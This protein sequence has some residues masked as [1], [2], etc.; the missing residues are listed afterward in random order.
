MLRDDAVAQVQVN[1]GF[2]RDL[3]NVIILQL[4]QAQAFY[5]RGPLIPWFLE[6]EY[7]T[8]TSTGPTTDNPPIYEDRIPLPATFLREKE[9]SMLEWLATDP[10]TTPPTWIPLDKRDDDYL[11]SWTRQNAETPTWLQNCNQVQPCVFPPSL[12]GP[13]LLYSINAKYYRIAPYPDKV[14][15]LRQKIY[16]QDVVLTANTENQWLKYA[17]QLLI[18]Y[19]TRVIAGSTGNQN[20]LNLGTSQEQ[21]ALVALQNDHEWREATNSSYAMGADL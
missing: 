15:T 19:A 10:S 14:Y 21:N 11:N 18:G 3:T 6:T 5:E 12:K 20:A 2:R 1:L 7:L 16:A 4:Q 9:N 13:P 8:T 17:P